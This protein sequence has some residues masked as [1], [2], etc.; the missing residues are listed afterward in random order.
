MKVPEVIFIIFRPNL[1]GAF[2]ESCRKKHGVDSRSEHVISEG[3]SQV[4]KVT[5]VDHGTG[6]RRVQGIRKCRAG[7]ILVRSQRSDRN[8]CTQLHV[9]ARLDV[10][11]VLCV[12]RKD[13]IGKEKRNKEQE[14]QFFHIGSVCY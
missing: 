13:N 8:S 14:Y 11:R 4:N 12:L 9:K 3:W 2:I 10:I 1:T 7:D 6:F 5:E